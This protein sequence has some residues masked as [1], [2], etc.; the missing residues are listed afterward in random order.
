LVPRSSVQP[1][2]DAP[3]DFE[4]EEAMALQDGY[5]PQ[6]NV[7]TVMIIDDSLS[8]RTIIQ[9]AFARVGIP[10]YGFAHGIA[11]I[12]ALA[13]DE[14]PVPNL[15]LLDIGMPK[16][17]GYEVASILRTTYGP[18]AMQIVMLT[19]HDGA[20][21]RVHSKL[22]KAKFIAKPFRVSDVVQT[23]CDLLGYPLPQVAR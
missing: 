15:V 12:A 5:G 8:I 20:K 23:V 18:E 13:R 3:W 17:D 9:A 11:A 16:M 2:G 14:V 10:V 21:D 6:A 22:I 4:G 1:A 19:A 7:P